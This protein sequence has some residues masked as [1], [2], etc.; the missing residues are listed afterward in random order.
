MQRAKRFSRFAISHSDTWF[1]F[2]LLSFFFRCIFLALSSFA[3]RTCADSA[4]LA[5]LG[6]LCFVVV[7]LVFAFASLSMTVENV[8]R[9]FHHRERAKRD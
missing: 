2:I 9:D 1:A 7:A 6:D 5:C 4:Y 3:S 8:M